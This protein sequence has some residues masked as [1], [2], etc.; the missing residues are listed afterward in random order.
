MAR[1]IDGPFDFSPYNF[2]AYADGSAW[3]LV[4]GEDY[5]IT[6]HTLVT[7]ARRW[8]KSQGLFP[9]HKY[10]TDP[11][12]VALRFTAV[13]RSN[14]TDFPKRDQQSEQSAMLQ[15]FAGIVTNNPDKAKQLLN[16]WIREFKKSS[17]S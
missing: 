9:E 2:A 14:V 3:I 13:D 5:T 7:N 1:K 4:K 15:Q 11:E 17:G 8:A 16:A 6:S 10:L 12:G